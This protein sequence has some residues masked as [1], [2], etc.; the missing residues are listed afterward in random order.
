VIECVGLGGMALA[1][2]PVVASFFGGRAADAIA[3]TQ[4]MAEICWARSE[5]FTIPA[6]DSAGA[7]VGIDARLVVELGVT[8]QIS[9]GVLH[10]SEGAG[11]IGAGV[12]HQ[13]LEP[14]ADAIVALAEEL[15]RA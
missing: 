13:P 11:Q 6:L 4:L 7:P 15:D 9:T 2:A 8:P 5:R 10:A 14:F 12:A 1:A 3:R